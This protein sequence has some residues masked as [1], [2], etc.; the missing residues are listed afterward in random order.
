METL[1]LL[2][3]ILKASVLVTV[4]G[5][6]GYFF[7]NYLSMGRENAKNKI[8]LDQKEIEARVDKLSLPDLIKLNNEPSAESGDDS[9]KS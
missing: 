9:D 3:N 7:I 8:K 2:L 1:E 4:L 6:V 5:L